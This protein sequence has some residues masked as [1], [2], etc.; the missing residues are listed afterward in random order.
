MMR[1]IQRLLLAI[2]FEEK[3]SRN[4]VCWKNFDWILRDD[5]WCQS[6]LAKRDVT[7][8]ANPRDVPSAIPAVWVFRTTPGEVKSGANRIKLM[9]G[10]HAIGVNERD[11]G[12]VL[13]VE[14][15]Y[16]VIA[17][18]K[19]KL[20]SRCKDKANKKSH[21]LSCNS[22]QRRLKIQLRP[23]LSWKSGACLW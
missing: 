18:K 6:L 19:H 15:Q 20:A 16:G 22:V 4:I 7:Q 9:L 11:E 17:V 1:R 3:K 14:S 5:N 10:I 21:Y 2:C 12:D 23:L 8:H 13:V